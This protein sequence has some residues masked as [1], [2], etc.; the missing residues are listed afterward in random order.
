MAQDDLQERSE[1]ATPKRLRDARERGQVPR[2]RELNT[3]AIL[4]VAAAA[5]LLLGPLLING[6]L[7]DMARGFA[8]SGDTRADPTQLP[9]QLL[10]AMLDALLLLA[11]LFALLMVTAALMP[12]A[13]GGW[14]LS[15]RALGAQWERLDPVKGLGRV[16]SVKG[17]VELLKSLA[18]LAFLGGLAAAWLWSQA[19]HF[20]ALGSATFPDGLGEGAM[21][22]LISFLIAALPMAAVAAID[23]PFQ[24]WDHARQL[25]MSRKE[26]KDEMKETDGS[27]ELK[28]RIRRQQQE[29]AGR[30]MMS[31]VPQ[32]DVIITN[33]SHY[34]VALIYDPATMRAPL[35]VAKGVDRVAMHIRDIGRAHAITR[36]EAPVLARALYWNGR[37]EEEIPAA[38]YLA[39]AQVLAYLFHLRETDAL[40]DDA[41]VID[42]L[43][44]PAH[45]RTD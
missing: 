35:L 33:P 8:P 22:V 28:A 12:M 5:M 36:V 30:R 4:L 43:P 29:L 32:A 6:L 45:L 37:L 41:V 7:S 20:L 26:L 42:D 1:E 39:V 24:L 9:A 17:L 2:S 38:L 19:E 18:K 25:R 10:S 3:F 14:T 13:L 44:V 21:L 27:P 40:G 16:F 11:P 15:S 34:A 23:V 31:R